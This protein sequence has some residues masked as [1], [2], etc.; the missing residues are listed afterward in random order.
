MFAVIRIARLREDEFVAARANVIELK[1][2]GVAGECGGEDPAGKRLQVH[3]SAVD[4][5]MRFRIHDRA[6]DTESPSARRAQAADVIW[7]R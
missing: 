6:A 1:A 5:E 2:P 3:A 4:V 7:E